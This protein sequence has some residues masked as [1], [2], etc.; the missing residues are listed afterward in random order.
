MRFVVVGGLGGFTGKS[1]LSFALK[2]PVCGQI[3][4][5]INCVP[6]HN[7]LQVVPSLNLLSRILTDLL[8]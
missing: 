7:G 8:H 1:C 6:P 5:R 2:L 3:I 4:G